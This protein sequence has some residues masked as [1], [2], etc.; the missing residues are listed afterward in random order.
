VG[1]FAVQIAKTLGAEVTAVCST[2]N[3]DMA[4][5]VGADH[6]IDYSKED[7]T[8]NGQRYDVILAVNGYHPLLDYRRALNPGGRY[9]VAGGTFRQIIEVL[10]AG[11]LLSRF[12]AKKLDFMGIAK[13]DPNDLL[14]LRDML[15][16]GQIKSVIDRTY[17]LNQTV[18]ALRYLMEHHAAGKVIITV[19]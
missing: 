8:T 11:R 16:I 3:Q 14:T 2:R 5:L 7:F 19:A 4:R 17:P 1:T 6:V 15:E 13:T 10:V 9:I 12:G 18:D